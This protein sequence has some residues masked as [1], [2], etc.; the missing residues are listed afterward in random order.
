VVDGDARGLATETCGV[1]L[2]HAH[3]FN[4][5]RG[6]SDVMFSTTVALLRSQGHDVRTVE[7]DAAR[8]KG[9]LA[10]ARA[11]VA[12]LHSRAARLEMQR[13]LRDFRPDV[14]HLHNLYPLLSPS[15]LEPCR[16]DGVPIVMSL[17]DHTLACPT[18][19]LFRDGKLC[20][21]CLGGHEYRA[22]L[23]RCAGG[24]V[25]SAA[26]ALR[27]ALPRV[28]G[29]FIENVNVFI[30]PSL[31]LKQFYVTEGYPESRIVHIPN[32]V[33]TP[34][35]AANPERGS[36][37]AYL[38][39][40][41]EEKGIASLLEAAARCGVPLQ[42]AGSGPMASKLREVPAKVRFVGRLSHREALEFLLDARC[43]VVPS[44]CAESFGLSGAEAMAL[45]IPV[46]ASRI[47]GLPETVPPDAGLFV[48][49]GDAA[50]LADAMTHMWE[51]PGLAKTLGT[52]GREFALREYSK[53]TYAARLLSLYRSLCKN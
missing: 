25:G 11:D 22:V 18:G 32:F 30:T 17:E 24:Y 29:T 8:V 51:N 9:T 4:A 14:V 34:A 43:V 12:S 20:R 42:I 10:E 15:I 13:L 6:G 28:R 1:R 33:E 16:T 44:L 23:T 27:T 36:Y 21:L 39:R 26:L 52:A 19:A 46:I 45:G 31:M 2:L 48:P 3:T 35:T 40:I 49:P 7:R 41:S 37:V 50:A 53:E 47:G 5:E 38:G